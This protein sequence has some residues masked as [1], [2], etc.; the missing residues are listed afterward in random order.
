VP[1]NV[2]KSSM[3]VYQFIVSVDFSVLPQVTDHIPMKAGLVFTAGLRVPAAYRKMDRATYFSSNSVFFV[4]CFTRSSSECELTKP[5]CTR[6]H[7]EH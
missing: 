1:L 7:R 6:V 3:F 4:Y 2:Q 5:F